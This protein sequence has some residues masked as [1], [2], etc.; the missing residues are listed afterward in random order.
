MARHPVPPMP[1]DVKETLCRQRYKTRSSHLGSLVPLISKV[2]PNK[3]KGV[4]RARKPKSPSPKRVQNPRG[5]KARSSVAI[6]P[7]KRR[8]KLL[9][10]ITQADVQKG[11]AVGNPQ[12]V[13]TI[14]EAALCERLGEPQ[15]QLGA[16]CSAVVIDGSTATGGEASVPST[17]TKREKLPKGRGRG[18]ASRKH[19][20][21]GVTLRGDEKSQHCDPSKCSQETSLQEDPSSPVSRFIPK[22]SHPSICT[23]TTDIRNSASSVLTPTEETDFAV[24]KPPGD[25]LISSLSRTAPNSESSTSQLS[26]IHSTSASALQQISSL[27][28]PIHDMSLE[29][30]ETLECE[31]TEME[32]PMPSTPQQ[33]MARQLARQKQLEEMRVR[34]AAQAR[35]ER[36]LRRQGLFNLPRKANNTK[37]IKW[38][39]DSDLVEIF[40]YLPTLE[41]SLELKPEH[42]PG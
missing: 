40:L 34:E 36:F 20:A 31:N 18:G 42:V 37:R 27:P 26:T 32:Y 16:V 41:D 1:A 15:R 13:N 12:A 3:L 6:P 29:S 4:K 35:E 39:D 2:S 19:K 5:G 33:K 7:K 9:V 11:T 25:T 17:R 24:L 8:R 23:D 30:D 28:N 38:K 14:S 22:P 10:E 21:G